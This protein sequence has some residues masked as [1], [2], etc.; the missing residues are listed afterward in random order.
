VLS[1]ELMNVVGGLM[2]LATALV[3]LDVKKIPVANLLPGL[4][5]PPVMVWVVEWL[6]P[7]MLM[8]VVG[9]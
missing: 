5:L 1:S 7:G 2:L 3:I 9:Q 4:F 8:G 6:S